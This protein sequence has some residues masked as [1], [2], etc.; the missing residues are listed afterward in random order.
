MYVLPLGPETKLSTHMK[1]VK[2]VLLYILI[3]ESS[4]VG[5]RKTQNILI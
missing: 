2:I 3:L 1:H 4:Y 5:H